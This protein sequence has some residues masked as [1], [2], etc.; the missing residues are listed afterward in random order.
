MIR[1]LVCLAALA[2]LAAAEEIR[3]AGLRA[4][5]EILVDR[6]GVPH[7]YARNADD[8][9]FVQG[10]NAARDR[11]FQIDLWRRR[12]LGQLAE[13][14]GAR[15][16]EQ[17]RAAR[18][19]LYRGDMEREWAAYGPLARRMAE[20]FAAGVNAYIQWVE[21][22]EQERLPPEFRWMDYRPARW[23]AEDVVRIRSH[24]LT[25]NLTGEVARARVLCA[26]GA[27]HGARYDQ[28]RRKLEPAWEIRLPE[29]LDPCLPEDVLAVYRLATE[30]VR[31]G[32]AAGS[33]N[34][35]IAPS[36]SATGRAVMASDPHRAYSTPSLRYIVHVSTPEMDFIGGGEPALPGVSIGHNGRVAFGLTRFYIDQEDLYVYELD[37]EDRRRYRYGDG[38]ERMRA[39]RETI[40]VKGA[41]T[42][43][44]ELAF[45][46]HGPVI[47]EDGR[48]AYAVRSA[49][50][51]PGTAAYFGSAS[52]AAARSYDEFRAGVG[53]AL[54]PGLN[55]VYADVEGNIGWVAGGLAPV[56]RNWDGLLP[57]PG[58]GRYE[59]AGF[60]EGADLPWSFN[61]ERQYVATANEMNL[62]ADYPAAERKLGFEWVNPSRQQRIEEVLG[63]KAKV[64]LEDSMRL[65]ND[66]TSL[67]A[68]R[69]TALLQ[70]LSSKDS[71]T[72]K[73]LALLRKWDGVESA[74]SGAAALFEVWVSRHLGPAF[75]RAV[76]PAAVADVVRTPDMA[77]MLEALEQGLVEE[78]DALL[79]R[80]LGA[81]Y[82]ETARL[83]GSREKTWAWGRLHHNFPAHP[84]LEAVNG[85]ARRRLQVGPFPKSGGPFTP[86]QSGYRATD[87]RQTGGASFRV[88]VD[89]GA[90]DES[91]AVN[92][93]GQSGN[94]DDPHYRDLAEMWGRGDYFPLLYSREA[95]EKATD[96]GLC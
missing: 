5:A 23:A 14:F 69:L 19:F 45:T 46:R 56:R 29:G 15:Y 75:V 20:A 47:W 50:A 16:V 85:E 94:P 61:P 81:A 28:V 40:R 51:E 49:W 64:T 39:V 30:A 87:F 17:D 67:P 24:G 11:L 73:A 48:R 4:P 13:A 33:N 59:W 62:P 52:Y 41:E 43:E 54:M 84:L 92:H 7:I 77:S 91:R 1:A 65:Q 83:L 70:A 26:G 25:G 42:V 18:L 71:R 35:A 80:T 86:N 57:V 58:D 66:I 74:D 53:R 34:W 96:G 31:F 68:R 60:W 72:R 37:P 89:V 2:G 44:A 10:F 90:W 88:V 79:L 22:A 12:G 82:R 36:K 6:W 93:P 76:L 9:F 38:W 63:P 78:R 21:E 55:Y 27:E 95:V 8:G 32:E 3:V